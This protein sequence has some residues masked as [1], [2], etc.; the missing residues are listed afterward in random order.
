MKRWIAAA[1]AVLALCAGVARQDAGASVVAMTIEDLTK[2]ADVCVRGQVVSKSC[3]WVRDGAMLQ[4]LVTVQVGE[5]LK[6]ETHGT[7]TVTVPGG[8]WQ[9]LRVRASEAPAYEQGEE[10]VL[11][12]RKTADGFVTYGCF[13]GKLTIIGGLVREMISTSYDDLRARILAVR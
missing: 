10:V 4:T 11:F 3:E 1:A 7:I 12:G 6:G 9:N 2:G 5:I 13:Q 8:D